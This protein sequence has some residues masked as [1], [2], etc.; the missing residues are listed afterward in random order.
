MTVAVDMR[1]P[2]KAVRPVPSTILAWVWQGP[3]QCLETGMCR[4]DN[5]ASVCQGLR[6][7]KLQFNA[8]RASVTAVLRPVLY[9]LL[10][11]LP[12]QAWQPH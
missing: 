5:D 4:R 7:C 8:M 9:A 12:E 11:L 6:S 2:L 3:T 10:H 1:E